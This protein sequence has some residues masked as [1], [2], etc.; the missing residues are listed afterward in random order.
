MF[1]MSQIVC[2]WQGFPAE[3]NICGLQLELPQSGAP[4]RCFTQVVSILT[5]KHQTKLERSARDKHS[6]LLRTFVKYNH[7]KFYNIG[8][9]CQCYKTFFSIN[10]DRANKVNCCVLVPRKS[11]SGQSNISYPQSRKQLGGPPGYAP[12]VFVPGNLSSGWVNEPTHLEE[13]P[14]VAQPGE[15]PGT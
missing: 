15:A 4:E 7:K 12:G 9:R 8:P 11:F 3:S 10:D 5:H 6:S 1:V 14:Q 13:V 2:P